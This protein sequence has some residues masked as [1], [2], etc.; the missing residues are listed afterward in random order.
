MPGFYFKI[1]SGSCG[2]VSRGPFELDDA[3]AAKSEAIAMFADFSR[4]IA[5]DLAASLEWSLDVLD[6]SEKLIYRIKVV[7]QAM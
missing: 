6:E 4:N 5:F 3:E 1:A 7:A 2:R